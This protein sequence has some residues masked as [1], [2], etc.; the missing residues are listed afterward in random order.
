MLQGALK[1]NVH[2]GA[3][4]QARRKPRMPDVDHYQVGSREE[5]LLAVSGQHDLW[6]GAKA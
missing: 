3:V 6:G 1:G 4:L 5:A 2:L